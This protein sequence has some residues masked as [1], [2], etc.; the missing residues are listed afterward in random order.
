MAKKTENISTSEFSKLSGLS[1]SQVSKLLRH[2]KIKGIKESGK[3]MI[4][5]NQLDL[6]AVQ[7]LTKNKKAAPSKTKPKKTR[8]EPG[9]DKKS[10]AKEQKA[11]APPTAKVAVKP[12][13][14]KTY[15]VAEFSAMTYLTDFGVMDWI[16]KGRL[17]GLQ[18]EAGEWRI[19]AAN[20]EV[21]D[22]KRLLRD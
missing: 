2:G 7:E 14:K 3:W 15:S 4:S 1:V 5:R 8:K 20:L 10:A 18:D 12:A 6:K 16:K 21:A 22:I 19:D 13:E 9:P 11:S 17:K